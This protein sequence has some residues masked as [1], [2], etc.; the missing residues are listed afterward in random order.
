MGIDVA[1]CFF[2][3][4]FGQ[5]RVVRTGAGN[6]HVVDHIGQFVEELREALEVGGIEGHSTVA[7]QSSLATY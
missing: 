4:E 2:E 7:R 1:A 3:I 5:R 6:Q